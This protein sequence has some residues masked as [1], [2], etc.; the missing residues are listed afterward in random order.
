MLRAQRVV[1]HARLAGEAR[2]AAQRGRALARQVDRV[3]EGDAPRARRQH[4][5]A[6]GE[7]HRLGDRVRDEQHRRAAVGPQ[8]AQ[9]V[10]ELLARDLVERGEGLVEQQQARLGDERARERHTHAHAARELRRIAARGVAEAYALDRARA[11]SRR[12]PAARPCSSSGSATLSST[13]RHGSR[14]A[15]WKT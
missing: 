2:I 5:G 3:I 7:E 10:V 14:C 12:S 1:Q 8:R 11:A 9:L 4:D 15:S 6:L 13:S